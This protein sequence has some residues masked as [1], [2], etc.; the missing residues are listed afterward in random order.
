VPWED[1]GERGGEREK[2]GEGGRS[3]TNLDNPPKPAFSDVGPAHYK[4][5]GRIRNEEEKGISLVEHQLCYIVPW[6]KRTGFW[7]KGCQNIR[8]TGWTIMGG[9]EGPHLS[10]RLKGRL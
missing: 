5:L 4:L 3:Y 2:A 6:K 10:A 9:S 7:V 1:T 8:K